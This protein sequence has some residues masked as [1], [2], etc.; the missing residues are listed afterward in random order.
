MTI[1]K[2]LYTGALATLLCSCGNYEKAE[3]PAYSLDETIHVTRLEDHN[4][5]LQLNKT[6]NWNIYTGNSP[7]TINWNNVQVLSETQNILN[8]ANPQP[9]K[10]LFFAAVSESD[11]LYLSERE[12]VLEHSFNF[13]DIGG[14]PTKD[15]KHTKFGMLYR[16]GEISELS[17]EDLAYME[18]IG[19]A[20]ILDLRSNYE[21]EE[22]PD[23][24]PNGVNWLHMPIGN[25]DNK[26]PKAMLKQITD[27]DPET[28]DGDAMMEQFSV[29]FVE[30]PEP[31]K[32]LFQKIVEDGDSPIL[33]HCSAGKD[34]TGFTSAFILYTLGVD[35]ETIMDE[36]VLS[37]FYRYPHNESTIKKAAT[38]YGIDERILRPLMGVKRSYLERGFK[39]IE[40]K[41]GSVDN[42]LQTEIGV[43]SLVQAKLRHRYLR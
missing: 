32:K 16:S 17:K 41:Y 30:H 43:D 40:A 6:G 9:A 29:E 11:T 22:Q 36:Y 15:G 5:E 14:I 4:Y 26:D 13:R 31:F 35:K 10:R 23:I 19:L 1:H 38:F 33:F 25:M 21:I 37:N 18:E 12:I 27:A 8:I 7:E 3:Q 20:T 34:R 2:F 39:E 24:Y 42:F 28:F